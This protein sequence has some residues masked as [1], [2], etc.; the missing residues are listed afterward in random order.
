MA[1][2]PSSGLLL[3]H[4]E[5]SAG[6]AGAREHRDE[7]RDELV[8]E[9]EAPDRHREDAHL[10][11]SSAW[12]A[13]DD[14]HPD[15]TDAADLRRAPSDAGAGKLAGPAQD[16]RARDAWSRQQAHPSVRSVR[17]DAAAELCTPDAVRSA[18]Q[19]CAAQAAAAAPEPL[20]LRGAALPLEAAAQQ[21]P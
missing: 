17:P 12:D 4:A 7:H 11:A 5:H 14:A 9:A 3:R 16:A 1:C 2:S 8:P 10:P 19:S 13:W 15:A 6:P 20:G 18:E 21:R